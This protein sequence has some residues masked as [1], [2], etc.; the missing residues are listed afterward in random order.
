MDGSSRRA[1]DKRAGVVACTADIDE[2]D[3]ARNCP[4]GDP[5]E[6]P[7]AAN[8]NMFKQLKLKFNDTFHK[9]SAEDESCIF[10]V[11]RGF[12]A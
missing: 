5:Y 6:Q 2:T 3:D 11:T 1:P 8:E 4:A 12:D 10:S 7:A 9:I